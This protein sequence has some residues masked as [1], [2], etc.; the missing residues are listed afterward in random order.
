VAGAVREPDARAVLRPDAAALARADAQPERAADD[1]VA[2]RDALLRAVAEAL[3][4]SADRRAE[5]V[6]QL[7]ADVAAAAGAERV[8]I[9]HAVLGADDAAAA[10]ALASS[11][12]SALFGPDDRGTELS[13]V[14]DPVP[15]PHDVAR[16][17]ADADAFV[18]AQHRAVD[19]AVD[20]SSF[21]EP[22][23][24]RTVTFAVGLAFV[25]EPN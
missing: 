22:V 11:V 10:G 9:L 3:D 25:D 20:S 4:R 7:S 17:R 24:S 18:L 14:A 2:V 1:V 19:A 6:A 23:D 21:H 8:S 12:V 5:S 16:G 15:E 13:A